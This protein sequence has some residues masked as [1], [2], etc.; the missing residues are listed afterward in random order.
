MIELIEEEEREGE[1]NVVKNSSNVFLQQNR[2]GTPFTQNA[3]SEKPEWKVKVDSIIPGAS[4]TIDTAIKLPLF[5]TP[6]SYGIV[7][8]FTRTIA[9][10]ITAPSLII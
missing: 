9:S 4:N 7:S 2:T 1:F 8:E 5:Q 6:K 3:L 10:S